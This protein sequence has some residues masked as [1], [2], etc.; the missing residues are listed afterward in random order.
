MERGECYMIFDIIVYIFLTIA[1]GMSI[2]ITGLGLGHVGYW[3]F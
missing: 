1:Y 3:C 2:F